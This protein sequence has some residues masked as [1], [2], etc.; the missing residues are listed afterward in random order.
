MSER[1]DRAGLFL[2]L[3][4]F[5]LLGLWNLNLPGLHYDEAREAG[6]NAMEFLRGLPLTAFRN[7]QIR[8]GP[9][10]IP[11]MVQDYIGA[12][13]VFLVTPFLGAFGIR[14]EALR[15]F[16]L[17]VGA[18]TIFLA[19][20]LARKLGGP[21]AGFG[22]ALLLA[23][24]PSF[25]F[26][27]RQGVFVTNIVSLF[28]VASLLCGLRWR[29]SGNPLDLY[30]LALLWGLGVY[31]KAIFLWA[32]LAMVFWALILPSRRL[33]SPKELVFAL[34][35]FFLPL[36]PFLLFNVLTGGTILAVARNLRFSYYGINN[37]ALG[38][39]LAARLKQLVTLLEGD[40]LW[41]LGG[42][43][44]NPAAPW[45]AGGF[46][47]ANLLLALAG[48]A[49]WRTL[50]P[51]AIAGLIVVESAFT[52]SGLFITHYFL[53]LPLL[54]ISGGIGLGLL[55]Q[56]SGP[57]R[58]L[59]ALAIAALI[60]WAGR[61]LYI[62]SLYHRALAAT[63]GHSAHSDAVYE[64]ARYTVSWEGSPVV[65]LD[66]GIDAPLRFLTMGKV[67][68]VEIFGYESFHAP[69]AGFRERASSFLSPGTIFIAHAPE[70]TVFKGRVEAL[71]TLAKEK[72]LKLEEIAY[73]RE[74]SG[75]LLYIILQAR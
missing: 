46:A 3:F 64:L 61:D 13:N 18:G 69:D 36:I 44:S 75:R 70:D 22:A 9:V 31:S 72:G 33:P 19:W 2:A 7:A 67:R 40:H 53:L 63:G 8:I 58:T 38:A 48:K 42:V 30:C 51:A 47:L 71:E 17:S 66:W 50:L 6:L 62:T 68:P 26:W 49:K 34:L 54:A 5:L 35:A 24:N 25:V 11:L 55:L 1:F 28:L 29:K 4:V 39:N 14:V 57:S 41:Y 12:L 20:V 52:I 73:F 27:S 16:T 74:R 37:L 59:K 10:D 21:L 45:V 65:A 23:F 15:L 43:F 56:T 60:L 32:I